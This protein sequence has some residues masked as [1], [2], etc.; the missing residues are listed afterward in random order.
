MEKEISSVMKVRFGDCDP[1]G[2]LNN[3][4]YLEYMLNAREDHVES[5]YGFT[6]EEFMKKT[7][8]TWIAVENNIAYLKEVLVNQ[9]VKITSKTIEITDRLAKV[10]IQ[11]KNL[12]G[13]IVYAI[14]WVTVI[15]FDVIT[16]KSAVHPQEVRILFERSKVE[17]SEKSFSDRVLYFRKQNKS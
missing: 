12:E 11:M 17:I 1:V 8:R 14:L 4:K 7:G 6:Y 15:C 2:H 13:N 9:K 5:Y 10:E 16:R 3:V